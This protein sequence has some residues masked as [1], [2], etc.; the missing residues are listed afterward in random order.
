MSKLKT[1]GQASL[2]KQQLCEI[3]GISR[4]TLDRRVAA[5]EIPAIY[6]H[7]P[8]HGR[9]VLFNLAKVRAAILRERIDAIEARFRKR[10]R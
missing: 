10:P 6:P 5:G 9:P 1:R 2:T 4:A 8:G 7:G 3:L